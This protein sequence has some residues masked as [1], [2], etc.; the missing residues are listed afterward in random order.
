MNASLPA[1]ASDLG[2]ADDPDDGAWDE[3]C[4]DDDF[5]KSFCES[6]AWQLIELLETPDMY[7][8]LLSARAKKLSAAWYKSIGAELKQ[9]MEG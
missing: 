2:P 6:R 8:T 7:P 3:L 9:R 1:R 5:K 4:D